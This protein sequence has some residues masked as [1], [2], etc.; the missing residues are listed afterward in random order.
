MNK[1]VTIGTRTYI[2][3]NDLL[4]VVDMNMNKTDFID[5]RE[6]HNVENLPCY[7]E[8]EF[9]NGGYSSVFELSKHTQE[10][11]KDLK[12]PMNVSIYEAGKVFKM[13]FPDTSADIWG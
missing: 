13:A 7:D 8:S 6:Y 3:Y 1:T 12:I 4:C 5:L 2:K 9:E 11:A 10:V